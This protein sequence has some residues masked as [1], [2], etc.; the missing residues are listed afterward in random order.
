METII[1]SVMCSVI[2]HRKRVRKDHSLRA[3]RTMVDVVLAQGE[4]DCLLIVTDHA[5]YDYKK[6][7]RKAQLV[8]DSRNA[9]R[10]I[11]LDKV[12]HC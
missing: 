4:Y 9:T 10:G 2:C 8:V 12:V 11:E 3:I 6:I 7:V 5:D 1:G